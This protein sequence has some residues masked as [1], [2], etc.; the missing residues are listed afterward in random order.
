MTISGVGIEIEINV[1]DLMM[2]NFV[3]SIKVSVM[4]RTF[5]LLL[6]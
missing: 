4:P 1:G 3:D 5:F 6:P 2:A